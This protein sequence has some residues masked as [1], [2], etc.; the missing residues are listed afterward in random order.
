M[1]KNISVT[2]LG[3][4]SGGGPILSRHCSSL[5]LN[6]DGEIWLVDCAEGTQL[7][8][9][10]AADLRISRVTKVF[11]THLHVDH[12]MGVIPLL[13]TIMYN[14]SIGASDRRIELYGP[15]GLR[16][17]IRTTLNITGATLAGRF[18]VHEFLSPQTPVASCSMSAPDKHPN[19]GDGRDIQCDDDGTWKSFQRASGITISAAP[20]LHRVPC[21]GYV[22]REDNRPEP[23]SEEAH[24]API[25]RNHYELIARGTRVPRSLL[26]KLLSTRQPIELPDGFLLE[27]PPLSIPGRKLVILGD[28]CDPSSILGLAEDASVLVHE[29]TN[30][31]TSPRVPESRLWDENEKERVRAKAISRGHSTAE[32]AGQFAK[33]IRT[34]RLYL[35][36]FS[37]RYPD[38]GLNSEDS[39]N[40]DPRTRD[41]R[42]RGVQLAMIRAIED[43]ATEAWGQEGSRAIAASDLM[44]VEIKNH[45]VEPVSMLEPS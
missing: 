19:E 13:T 32:M 21:V 31:Y 28:T 20:L 41:S 26:G 23:F 12:V 45:E 7:Q 10:Q 27:P 9:A 11:I 43:Q 14:F 18:S 37:S 30:A 36:H 4:C 25:D 2:F 24:L 44:S 39:P 1:P 38:P 17:L 40:G 29:A 8:L 22:F 35:N 15:M 3:T 6:L 33:Q 5:A 42:E 16:K 34:R